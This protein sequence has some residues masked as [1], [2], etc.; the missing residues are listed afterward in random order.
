MNGVPETD[1][2]SAFV[3]VYRCSGGARI[4]QGFDIRINQ[5]PADDGTVTVRLLTRYED[6]GFDTGVPRELL[7]EIWCAAQSAEEARTVCGPVAAGI[8]AILS[9]ETN[10]TVDSPRL[11]IALDATPGQTRREFVQ[12]YQ[13]DESGPLHPGRFV[14]ADTFIA[15]LLAAHTTPHHSRLAR[16]MSQYEAA[17]RSWNTGGL[18]MVLAHLYMAAEALTKPIEQ[19]KRDALGLN[20]VE[21]AERLGVDTSSPEDKPKDWRRLM[22]TNVRREYIFRGDQEL[23]KKALDA[24]DGLEHGFADLPEIRATATE[25]GGRM[26]DAIREA[27]LDVLDLSPEVRE[28]VASRH[29]VDVSEL[30]YEIRGFLTGNVADVNSIAGGDSLYPLLSWESSLARLTLN[31]G[32]LEASPSQ[33]YAHNFAEGVGFEPSSH[34]VFGGMNPPEALTPGGPVD[35]TISVTLTDQAPSDMIEP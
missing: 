30:W 27:I 6:A 20:E 28:S 31:E 3:L 23:Y 15:V 4:R 21:H 1:N 25:I 35:T 22:R 13:D 26:F 11:H 32:R 16:A 19:M 14:D 9:F 34:A 12:T 5:L 2:R 7:M 33:S 18:V 10:V 29:P 17:L 24:S 8:A